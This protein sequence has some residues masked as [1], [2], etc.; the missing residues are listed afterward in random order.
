MNSR[1]SELA[2]YAFACLIVAGL[3]HLVVVLLIPMTATR[4][5]FSRLVGFA[6]PM[7]TQILP[8]ASPTERSFPFADPAAAMAFCRFDLSD[9][10]VRIRAPV[11]RAGFA[12]LSFHTRRGAVIY[13][14]TDR[15]AT[16]ERMEA[17]VATD[18]QLRALVAADDEDNPSEDL[19]ILSPTVQGYALSRVLTD[20]PGLRPEAEAQAL[21]LSC[22]PDDSA[23]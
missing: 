17:V 7:T 6:A 8:P 10:P 11:G 9:G 23:K 13:A 12:S 14:L 15:A 16:R 3:T 18:A 2:L 19:R 1:L 4:D 20:I 22:I 5:A 21:K